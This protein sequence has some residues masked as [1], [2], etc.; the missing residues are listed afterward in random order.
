M[1]K[2]VQRQKKTG[3]KKGKNAQEKRPK[4]KEGGK[5]KT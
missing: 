1:H 5:L 4:K 3:K 2:G